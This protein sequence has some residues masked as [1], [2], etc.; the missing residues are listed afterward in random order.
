MKCVL[1]SY[2]HR[3]SLVG[4]FVGWLIYPTHP[5]STHIHVTAV[6]LAGSLVEGLAPDLM[7]L[8]CFGVAFRHLHLLSLQ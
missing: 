3:D 2:M 1:R 5:V 8:F 6:Y 4:L 7:V